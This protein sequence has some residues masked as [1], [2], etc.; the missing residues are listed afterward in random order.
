MKILW[1]LLQK[2]LICGSDLVLRSVIVLAFI[3][4]F[5]WKFGH[6]WYF[7]SLF[8]WQIRWSTTFIGILDGQ[9]NTL[10]TK[11]LKRRCKIGVSKLVAF[12]LRV[13]EI[14]ERRSQASFVFKITFS[15]ADLAISSLGLGFLFSQFT[16]QSS[17]SPFGCLVL[18]LLTKL[19]YLFQYFFFFFCSPNLCITEVYV[20]RRFVVQLK[21]TIFFPHMI[22]Q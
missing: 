19:K 5:G 21:V 14:W 18:S 13:N 20:R 7:P 9:W 22:C 2:K 3:F 17:L 10:G 6:Y 8:H 16:P 15:S 4:I 11:Q 1:L 12:Q